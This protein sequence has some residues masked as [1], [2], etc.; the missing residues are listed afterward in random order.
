MEIEILG[1]SSKKAIANLTNLKPTITIAEIK[2]EIEKKN[3]HY[4]PERQSLRLEPRGKSLKDDEKLDSLGIPRGGQ[5]YLKDLGPQIG[6]G[7]V[8]L[9]EY[10][11]PLFVYLWF[12]TRP[13]LI[14]GNGASDLPMAQVVH[15][16][17]ACWAGHYA[18]R[19]LETIFVHRFSHSTMPIRNLFKNCTYYWGFTAYVAYYVNHPLYTTPML[20]SFQVYLSLAAFLLC[21]LG[22]FSIHLAFKNLRPEGSTERKIPVATFNP[23]TVMFNYVSCPNYTYEVG[24]WAAFTV[25]TQCLPAGLFA[26]AG[27]V[28]MAIWALQKHGNYKKEFS[29]YPRGRRAIIPFII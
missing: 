20:G 17:A 13:S 15:I 21:E 2:R 25:M 18:K 19:V 8:F 23:F 7:T 28:Q 9:L 3:S 24:S 27:F 12:Y 1:T 10:T 22:N 5:L 6:W 26:F 4:Y 16:A 29:N 14:Y 11:G